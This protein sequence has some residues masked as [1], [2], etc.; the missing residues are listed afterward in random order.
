MSQSEAEEYEM[1]LLLFGDVFG[2][3]DSSVK[4]LTRQTES[5]GFYIQLNVKM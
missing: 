3:C 1:R 2:I 4:K 5:C